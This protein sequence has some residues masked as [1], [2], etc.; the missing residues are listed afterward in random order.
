MLGKYEV[1]RHIE[2]KSFCHCSASKNS[3]FSTVSG[4]K[5]M[6]WHRSKMQ[7]ATAEHG[8]VAHR[9]AALRWVRSLSIISAA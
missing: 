8:F 7:S 3:V 2:K 4:A 9:D 5:Q 1:E 6:E